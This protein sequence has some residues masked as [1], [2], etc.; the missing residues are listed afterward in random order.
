MSEKNKMSSSHTAAI[1]GR[2]HALI[3]LIPALES[4][5]SFGEWVFDTTHKGT[6][7]DPKHVPFYR[8][9]KLVESIYE[10][11]NQVISS[12]SD[13]CKLDNPE[14]YLQS[15][16][17]D[18][19]QISDVDVSVQDEYCLLAFL[20][21]IYA[22]ERFGDGYIGRFYRTGQVLRWLKRLEEIES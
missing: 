5:D 20:K 13:G 12:M 9:S 10:R 6:S 7:D 18:Y 19:R 1:G 4:T 15:I 22:Y 16:G 2:F 11:M 17:I 3:S 21:H 8:Y 14:M